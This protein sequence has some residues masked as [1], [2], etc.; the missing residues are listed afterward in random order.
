MDNMDEELPL[1]YAQME[2]FLETDDYN[3]KQ[4]ILEKMLYVE[5]DPIVI[6]NMAAS[7]DVVLPEGD[8]ESMKR[9]LLS[10]VKTRARFDFK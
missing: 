8:I 7:M 9:S 10:C 4:D 6:S 2:E 1:G 3:V 5:V